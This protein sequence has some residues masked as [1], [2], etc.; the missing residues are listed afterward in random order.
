MESIES[1]PATPAPVVS[2]FGPGALQ[3]PPRVLSVAAAMHGSWK[4]TTH[5]PRPNLTHIERD[6]SLFPFP[7]PRLF[8]LPDP[9]HWTLTY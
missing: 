4:T 3:G 5:S 6:Y 2:A 7:F 9:A 1:S 8:L